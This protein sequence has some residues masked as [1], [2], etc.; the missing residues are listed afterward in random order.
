MP[1]VAPF[2]TTEPEIPAVYHNNSDCEAGQKIKPEHR[3][4]GIG[5][6]RRLCRRCVDLS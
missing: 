3:V 4:S 5:T 2:H 1:K 6:G